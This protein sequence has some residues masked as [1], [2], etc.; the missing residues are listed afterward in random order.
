MFNLDL[1]DPGP[2]GLRPVAAVVHARDLVTTD[3]EVAIHEPRP[4][5]ERVVLDGQRLPIHLRDAVEQQT[6][7]CRA[8]AIRLRIVACGLPR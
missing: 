4:N 5:V 2:A 7:G 3:G 8:S 6:R 1:G